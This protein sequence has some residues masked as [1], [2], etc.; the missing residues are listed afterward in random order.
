MTE[1]ARGAGS[2]YRTPPPTDQEEPP[3][4]RFWLLL[5]LTPLVVVV[6]VVL[7]GW[8]STLHPA[9]AIFVPSLVALGWSFAT[10]VTPGSGPG[11]WLMTLLLVATTGLGSV[12]TGAGELTPWT[13]GRAVTPSEAPSRG[14]QRA[15][16]LA[17]ATTRPD[18]AGTHHARGKKGGAYHAVAPL[19]P[20]G[21]TPSSPVPAW[22]VCPDTS[23]QILTREP[24]FAVRPVSFV[25]DSYE[26]ASAVAAA[27]FKLQ[28]APGAPVLEVGA[29]AGDV[30][31][32]RTRVVRSMIS[33]L[34]AAWL[35]VVAA[36]Q[37]HGLWRRARVS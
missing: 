17:D 24:R 26:R 31:A 9:L 22:A 12:F 34:G 18:L 15:F 33:A 27:R 10:V 32:A 21:W 36:E 4:R 19:V 37:L 20:P 23:C 2:P 1:P 6:N 5:A 16:A 14:T 29:S 30:I 28:V 8:M 11:Q 3:S 35:L 13:A 25:R 7:S